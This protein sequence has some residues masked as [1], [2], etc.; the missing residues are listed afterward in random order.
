MKT[1]SISIAILLII[2]TISSNS[3]FAAKKDKGTTVITEA[4]NFNK[5]EVRGN[6][7]VYMTAGETNTVKVNNNYYAESA[8]VQNQNGTLRISSF[9]KDALVVYVT[10]SEI[11][12]IAL[13][14]NAFLKSGKGISS[15]ELNVNL[16]NNAIA[17]L[18]LVAYNANI[19]VN[20][21][22]KID[23]SGNVTNCYMVANQSSTVNSTNFVAERIDRKINKTAIEIVKADDLAIIM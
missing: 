19:T 1:K 20:D 10:V 21:H 7:E 5:I 11:N 16:F 12:S 8:L 17:Q 15:I 13:Y 14:D 3:V 6:V 2:A 23:L 22:A 4:K 9:S 18:D